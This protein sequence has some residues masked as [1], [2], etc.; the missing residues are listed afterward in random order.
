MPATSATSPARSRVAGALRLYRS[1]LPGSAARI[2]N[3]HYATDR[4]FLFAWAD[5]LKQE[6]KAITDAG[7][8]LQIDDPSHRRGLGPDQPRAQRQ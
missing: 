8:T 5:V 1:P 4:D 3:K 2:G 6:Y 7:L